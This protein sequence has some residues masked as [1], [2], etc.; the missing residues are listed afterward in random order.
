MISAATPS[1]ASASASSIESPVLPVAV[2]PP[3]TTS[4]GLALS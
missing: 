4:G 1:T 2:G 3:M